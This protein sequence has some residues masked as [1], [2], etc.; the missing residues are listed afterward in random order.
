M[1][2][3]LPVASAFTI[4]MG[5]G[6]VYESD[7]DAES[8]A[9]ADAE[10]NAPSA[11]PEDTTVTDAASDASE[12]KDASGMDVEVASPSDAVPSQATNPDTDIQPGDA[13]TELADTRS[14]Q[15]DLDEPLPLR[16]QPKLPTQETDAAT[17][18]TPEA[19]SGSDATQT[20]IKVMPVAPPP[21]VVQA[22]EPVAQRPS[23]SAPVATGD[24]F[25]PARRDELIGFWKQVTI[26]GS[27]DYDLSDSW[28]Q[29]L[30]Y[31][32]FFDDN[33]LRVIVFER[34]IPNEESLYTIRRNGPKRTLYE[35][36]SPNGMIEIT[37]LNG[38]RYQVL[39]TYYEADFDFSGLPEAALSD[40]QRNQYPMRG[41]ITLTYMDLGTNRPLFFRL[42]R[43]VG[44]VVE[45]LPEVQA[46]DPFAPKVREPM[47]L[48]DELI[49]LDD[50]IQR[51]LDPTQ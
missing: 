48:P 15:D 40:V 36:L 25:R 10:A 30:Q 37:Y 19:T 38:S 2:V 11:T 29:G 6:V 16:L 43:R 13:Y 5:G 4:K 31:W 14:E 26:K 34:G 49:D 12:S 50:D 28:Y 32:E 24:G 9:E 17:S 22:P 18:I 44:D 23:R 3:L 51:D 45:P 8:S 41:D 47:A 33:F 35:Y 20:A 42:L 39:A 21:E 1:C 27:S 46:Q 7:T